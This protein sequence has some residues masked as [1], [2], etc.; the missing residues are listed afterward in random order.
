MTPSDPRLLQFRQRLDEIDVQLLDLLTERFAVTRQVG[1]LK[2]DLGLSP[3]DPAR[4]AAQL[5]R[6]T[7]LAKEKGL[8]PDIVTKIFRVIVD[9]V[10]ANHIQLQKGQHD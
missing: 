6:L 7:A 2:H 5:E 8:E 4:E 9:A 10:V 3:R 1:E